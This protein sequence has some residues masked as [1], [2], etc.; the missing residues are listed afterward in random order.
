MKGFIEVT[1]CSDS[2]KCLLSVAE[3]VSVLGLEP[4]FIEV[5]PYFGETDPVG[6]EVTESYEEVK[7]LINLAVS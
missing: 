5:F 1:L 7:G 4:C 6:V 2:S 3:I